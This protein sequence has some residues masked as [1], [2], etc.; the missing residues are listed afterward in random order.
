MMKEYNINQTTLKI[1]GLYRSNYKVSLHLREIARETSVDVKAIQLQLKKLEKMNA[2][3][4][5][6]K[7]RNKDYSLNFSNYMVKYYMVLA[8]TF[9]SINYLDKNFEI[10]KLVSEIEDHLGNIA[11]LF[12]SFAKGEVTEESDVDLLFVA[13]KKPDMTAVRETGRLIDREISV[14]SATEEQFLKGLVSGDPLTMEVIANHVVLKGID[15]LCDIL[16]RYYGR[17]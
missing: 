12:G 11:I 14:K 9:A 13:D 15:N 3:Q 1:L 2:I 8:E 10:K 17:Q 6:L 5:T 4:A 7:G 16:W